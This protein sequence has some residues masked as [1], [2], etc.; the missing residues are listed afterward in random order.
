MLIF[1]SPPPTPILLPSL[2]ILTAMTA[3]LIS[4]A[5][6]CTCPGSENNDSNIAACSDLTVEDDGTDIDGETATSEARS[7]KIGVDG[8]ESCGYVRGDPC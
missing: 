8:I 2:L 7:M 4:L 6:T 5:L 3:A 1:L